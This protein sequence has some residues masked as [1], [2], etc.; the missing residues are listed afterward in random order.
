[1]IRFFSTVERRLATARFALGVFSVY[2]LIKKL[3]YVCVCAHVHVRT[4]FLNCTMYL[5]LYPETFF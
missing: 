4:V 2:T 1:M 3:P 5:Y